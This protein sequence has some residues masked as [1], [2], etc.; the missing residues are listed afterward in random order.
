VASLDVLDYQVALDNALAA[1]GPAGAPL[2]PAPLRRQAIKDA[3]RVLD[4]M[5]F[6]FALIDERALPEPIDYVRA[7]EAMQPADKAAA[8]LA[9]R[10]PIY[11]RVRR[12]R[13]VTSYS[14][15]II[16]GLFVASLVYFGTSETAEE[17]ALI[18]YRTFEPGAV[19]VRNVSFAVTPDM[20]RLH[21]DGTVIVDQDATGSLHLSLI[22]PDGSTAFVV[23]YGPGGTNYVRHNIYAPAAGTWQLRID[24]DYAA[25]TARVTVDGIRAAR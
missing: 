5:A 23:S 14:A 3:R 10:A 25:A 11:R 1:R 18:N 17:L 6:R 15:L 24:Y 16:I 12:R 22:A 20:N 2:L 19:D 9:R 4:A 13:R 21:V 8:V 7:L